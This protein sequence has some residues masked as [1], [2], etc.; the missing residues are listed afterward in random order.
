MY[1]EKVLATLPLGTGCAKSIKALFGKV[2]QYEPGIEF[3]A[4]VFEG[5]SD[6]HPSIYNCVNTHSGVGQSLSKRDEVEIAAMEDA[7]EQGALIIGICRGAQL[8]C[9]MAGG[10]LVQHVDGH[11]G[12]H[13]VRTDENQ[14]FLISSVHHQQMYPWD[15]EHDLLAWSK[16]N[17]AT[18]YLGDNIDKDKHRVEP[19]AC[20]FPEINALAFQWHPEWPASEEETNFTVARIKEKLEHVFA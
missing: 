5:G 20:Y 18:N 13:L 14:E 12:S 3:D 7:I 1:K 2:V 17:R 11:G 8:A 4:I 9:A 15:V 19:E 16:D 6:I 10:K